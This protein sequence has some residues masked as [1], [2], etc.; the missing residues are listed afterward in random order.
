MK[1]LLTLVTLATCVLVNSRIEADDDLF[2][3]PQVG[4]KISPFTISVPTKEN[5]EKKLDLVKE[6]DG[7]PVVMIFFDVTNP[8]RI[9]FGLARTVFN[10]AQTK[11]EKGLTPSL[12]LLTDD[13]TTAT[14]RA[15]TWKQYFP[16]TT[17]G[18]YTDGREGPGA[19]GLNRNVPLTI[20]VAKDN[21]VTANFAIVQPS[22]AVDGPKIMK[23]IVEATGGGKVPSVSEFA[24]GYERSRQGGNARMENKRDDAAR[25]A[26]DRT[27]PQRQQTQQ[28]PNL[29][30]YLVPI[31][32]KTASKE[33]VDKAVKELEKYLADKP[34]T[35]VEVG[36]I[37][38]RI[39]DADKLSNYGTTHAQTYLKKWAAEYKPA[40]TQRQRRTERDKPS[41]DKPATN[42]RATDKPVTDRPVT[43]RPATD[44]RPTDK[45]VSDKPLTK[46]RVTNRKV[47]AKKKVDDK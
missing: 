33:A 47:E 8:S 6:A 31:I 36:N 44:K 35:K 7:K 45:R 1:L 2:S 18:V 3:G 16:K 41:T 4:E 14:K 26:R 15:S 40:R 34:Q 37:A 17:M 27:T 24:P 32:Q 19:Y 42:R 23:A 46:K 43:D 9:A 11:K 12:V 29:R 21:V 13:V 39:I 38:R 20:L 25:P 10:F 30:G 5:S 22:A 28:D